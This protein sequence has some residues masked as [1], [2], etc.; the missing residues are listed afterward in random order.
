MAELGSD[1]AEVWHFNP[2]R[3]MW[4][5]TFHIFSAS[6]GLNPGSSQCAS[7]LM[8]VARL[9][10]PVRIDVKLIGFD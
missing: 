6:S 2:V 8:Q 1:F 7:G 9:W 10:F 4:L 5:S 3:I